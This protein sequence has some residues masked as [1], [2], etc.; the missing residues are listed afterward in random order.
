LSLLDTSEEYPW[1][2]E[3]YQWDYAYGL[4]EEPDQGDWLLQ[5]KKIYELGEQEVPEGE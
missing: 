5:I 2:P 4:E 3:R 1:L